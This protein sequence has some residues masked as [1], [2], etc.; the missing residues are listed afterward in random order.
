MVKAPKATWSWRKSF[1]KPTRINTPKAN[2]CNLIAE[3]E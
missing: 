3:Y 2:A 1:A